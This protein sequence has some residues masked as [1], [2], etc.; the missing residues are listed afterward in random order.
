MN[1]LDVRWG[2]VIIGRLGGDRVGLAGGGNKYGAARH[3][4]NNAVPQ[5]HDTTGDEQWR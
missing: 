2:V 1:A 3:T 5:Q 4:V